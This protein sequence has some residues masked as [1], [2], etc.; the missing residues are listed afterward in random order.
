MILNQYK[1]VIETAW[2]SKLID[3]TKEEEKSR[4]EGR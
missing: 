3:E 4:R 2:W 1:Y